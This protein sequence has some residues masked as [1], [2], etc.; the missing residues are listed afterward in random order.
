ADRSVSQETVVLIPE[1]Q[2]YQPGETAS[3]LVQAPFAPAEGTLTIARSG[4]V[5]QQRFRMDA[6]TTTLEVPVLEEHIPGFTVQIDLVGQQ[7]RTDDHGKKRDDLA[8]RTAF[9]TGSLAFEVP[10]LARKLGVAVTPG[11]T[12]VSP[13]GATEIVVVVTDADGRPVADA[14]LAVVAADDSVL[15]LSGYALPD[16]LAVFYAA[17]EPGV[18][19]F[20]LR[21]HVLLVDATT[22][23]GGDSGLGGLGIRGTGVAPSAAPMELQDA[24]KSMDLEGKAESAP[25]LRRVS[26]KLAEAAPDAQGN[27]MPDTA[28]ALRTNFDALALFAPEV[29]TDASG[30]AVVPL[31]LPDSLTR[32]RVMVV[33]VAG[34]KQ[35]GSGE[36]NVTAR[37]PLMVRPSP[38][39]FLNF[40]D[41][42]EL[43]IVLQNG[44]DAA[45][46]VDLAVRATNVQFLEQ[47]GPILPDDAGA[48]YSQRGRRVTVPAND[49]IEVRF[50]LAALL[51][52]TARFQAVAGS[53]AVSDA[54]RFELPVWTPATTEA[55]ATYGTTTENAVVQP[56]QAPPDVWPQFG[57]LQVQTS[58]T[59]LQALTD[60]VVYLQRYPYDCNE[61]IASRAMGIAALRDV[62]TAFESPD[63]P[64]AA[65]L[66]AQVAHDLRRLADRQNSDGGFAFWRR[67]DASWPYL[68]IYGAHAYAEAKRKRYEVPGT[69][70]TR[71]A[72]YLKNIQRHIPGWYSPEE[73]WFLRSYA[74]YVRWRMGDLDVGEAKAILRESGGAR[75]SLEGHGLLLPVLHAANEKALVAS[76]L[77]YLANHA[78][79]TAGALAFGEPYEHG[80]HVLLASSRRADGVVLRGLLSVDPMN[81]MV[82]KIVKGLLGHRKNGHWSNTQED[83]FILLALDTYFSVY[84]KET[85]DFVA[86]VWLGDGYV[87]DHAF[88]GRTTETAL[89]SI[90]MGYL[91]EKQGPQDLVIDREGTGR[92][93]YRI[94]M[95]YAPRSLALEPADHGFFV[96]RT[97]EAI[98]DPDDVRRDADGTW[99]IAAGKPVRV[100]LVMVAQARRY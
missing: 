65:D 98:E 93:Y 67:G 83:T 71:S 28:I 77:Q 56:V 9:A 54:A 80:E 100:R 13:G 51:A 76:E 23:T 61:Q 42:A 20:D 41:Q 39:R 94:G 53:G 2:E 3:F 30:R 66:E 99:R 22:V 86:R 36:S 78:T 92:L 31:K 97:Y 6:A 46:T 4:I 59:Q 7:T 27:A 15:A 89:S 84:E 16:P 26:A 17:R 52:G 50:P 10:P 81:D 38:P 14:E 40:G 90:P 62:L 79:E 96:Q 88:R 91:T 34:G 43:P 57:G 37:L 5:R 25:V 58:S 72:T 21:S 29:R 32:Y 82:P 19:T 1:K 74:A 24:S 48:P 8:R 87:G 60:A 44:T 35:F 95:T 75:L 18:Q 73:K 11:A 85:P 69:A 68:G 47:T 45:M 12:K 63:L 49:R 55:F 70:W 64:P 33:A